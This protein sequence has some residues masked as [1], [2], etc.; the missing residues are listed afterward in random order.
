MSYH[1]KSI[2]HIPVW[3]IFQYFLWELKC[4]KRN[5]KCLKRT[6]MTLVNGEISKSHAQNDPHHTDFKCNGHCTMWAKSLHCLSWVQKTSNKT[7]QWPCRGWNQLILWG[8]LWAEI[9]QMNWGQK[10]WTS[11]KLHLS[12]YLGQLF[13]ADSTCFRKDYNESKQKCADE[14]YTRG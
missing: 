11:P 8:L 5:G 1:E 10:T 6:K 3:F 13:R 9:S 7:V 14:A 2:R 12:T 4:R